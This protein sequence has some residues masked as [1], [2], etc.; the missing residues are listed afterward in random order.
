MERI[1]LA[2]A[3]S[4][5]RSKHRFVH[6]TDL[7]YKGDRALANN[8]VAI[9]NR[10]NPEFVCFTGDLIEDAEF[11]DEA[12]DVLSGIEAPLFAVP[13][14]HDYWT[15]LPMSAF[16]AAFSRIGAHWMLNEAQ[17]VA[18]GAVNLIGASCRS[19]RDELPANVDNVFNVLLMHYPA[20]CRKV[21]ERRFDLM[22]AGHSHGGQV[23]LPFVGP[24]VVPFGVD[25]FD[26]GM[27]ETAA[28]PLY[29]NGGIGWFTVPM[30]FN[31][32]PEITL[33]EI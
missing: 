14:N 11:L 8:L 10:L 27:F 5:P 29:V 6:F 2:S 12:V 3:I 16:V 7:H 23:R 25:E 26:L 28:G 9:I 19:E 1:S 4:G 22:L 32:R 20:W 21:R 13:G 15:N 17:L 30:R 31:C 18:D 33:F 24:L